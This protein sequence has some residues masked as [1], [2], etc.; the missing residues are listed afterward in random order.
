MILNFS[1]NNKSYV[2]PWRLVLSFLILQAGLSLATEKFAVFT[3]LP[4][5]NIDCLLLLLGGGWISIIGAIGAGLSLIL[6]VCAM[7]SEIFG[8]KYLVFSIPE[9]WVNM[10]YFPKLIQFLMTLGGVLIIALLIGSVI[11]LGVERRFLI[12]KTPSFCFIKAISAI[13]LLATS[14][15]VGE[16]ITGVNYFGSSYLSHRQQLTYL[17]DVLVNNNYQQPFLPLPI[18]DSHEAINQAISRREDIVLVVVESMGQFMDPI[19]QSQL[20]RV[21]STT[22]VLQRYQV[23]KSLHNFN[24]S[25]I[26][27][28]FRELCNSSLQNIFFSSPPADCLPVKLSNMGYET[29]AIHGNDAHFYRRST[30]YPGVGFQ[31]VTDLKL[32][33]DI[34]KNRCGGTWDGYCDIDLLML[35]RAKSTTSSPKFTY[36]LTLNTHLPA[37]EMTR[38]ISNLTGC[39]RKYPQSICIHLKNTERV[40]GAIAQ[41]AIQSMPATL[42]VVGDHAP[43]FALEDDRRL[44]N[45]NAVPAFLLQPRSRTGG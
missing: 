24:G 18:T 10:P 43:P 9:L 34:D 41:L 7:V 36:I 1:S 20:D 35:A 14:A 5:F 22:D 11:L 16:T 30:W 4:F 13:G 37:S 45:T 31:R 15:Y 17:A 12:N 28:E 33:P 26:H 19:I 8:Y 25:T 32:L 21:L 44:F 40:L 23:S 3:K 39:D 6:G 27:G 38:G 29:E 2:V 42:L